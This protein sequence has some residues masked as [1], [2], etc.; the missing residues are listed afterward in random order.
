MDTDS[1]TVEAE[2]SDL[3]QATQ[4]LPGLQAQLDAIDA[5]EDALGEEAPQPEFTVMSTSNA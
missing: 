1:K 2:H 3:V 4:A 5:L